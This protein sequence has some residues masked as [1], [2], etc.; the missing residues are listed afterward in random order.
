[1]TKQLK[2]YLKSGQKLIVAKNSADAWFDTFK[3]KWQFYLNPARK[4]IER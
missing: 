2:S 1:M 4:F 3:N